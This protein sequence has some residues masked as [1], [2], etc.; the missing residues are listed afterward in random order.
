MSELTNKGGTYNLEQFAGK[1]TKRG[2]G[3][4]HLTK[5]MITL[6]FIFAL[7]MITL[8]QVK[9]SNKQLFAF[10]KIM[11]IQKSLRRG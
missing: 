4:I 7:L 3:I 8:K 9:E 2:K 11:I 6:S 1:I 5:L 10:A